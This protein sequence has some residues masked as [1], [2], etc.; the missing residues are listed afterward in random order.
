MGH[1][2]CSQI[3]VLPETK[4]GLSVLS[5]YKSRKERGQAWEEEEAAAPERGRG[6]ALGLQA[7]LLCPSTQ[8][9]FDFPEIPSDA[10][11]LGKQAHCQP[12]PESSLAEGSTSRGRKGTPRKEAAARASGSEGRGHPFNLT[13]T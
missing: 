12:P 11:C 6:K 5:V 3:K 4:V 13:L 7:L 9:L 1:L 8:H 10:G 2:S